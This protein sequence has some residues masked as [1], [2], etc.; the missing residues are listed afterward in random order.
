MPLALLARILPSSLQNV[1]WFQAIE[2][3]SQK[4]SAVNLKVSKFQIK[5]V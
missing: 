1:L 3:L 2:G 4:L 5:N